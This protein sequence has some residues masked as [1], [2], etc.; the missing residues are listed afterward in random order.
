M[1]WV[2]TRHLHFYQWRILFS[3]PPVPQA[4][5]APP[6]PPP[7]P[8]TSQFCLHCSPEDTETELPEAEPNPVTE[9]AAMLDFT[10]AP[11]HQQ[12]LGDGPPTAPPPRNPLT[13]VPA[14]ADLGG[15]V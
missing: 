2:K 9:D 7:F 14:L 5:L 4:P 1:D 12:T 11:D 13:W 6:P 15:C 10:A 3:T 8:R